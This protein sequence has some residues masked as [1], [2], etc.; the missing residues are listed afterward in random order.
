VILGSHACRTGMLLLEH[1]GIDYR[2]VELPTG[3]HPQLVRLLGFPGR[4]ATPRKVEGGTNPMLA[5][6]DRFGTVPAV[7][8]DGDRV[9]TNLALIDWLDAHY[10]EPPL[11]PAGDEE[12]AQVREA[13]LWGNEVLQMTARRLVFA[14]GL[15]EL[16]ALRGRASHGRMGPLLAHNDLWRTAISQVAA[17]IVFSATPAREQ[18]LRDELADQLGVVDVWLAAGILN[19]PRLNA[20]D[21]MIATSLAL[22]SYVPALEA[23][24]E[25]RPCGALMQRVLPGPVGPRNTPESDP[26]AA[27]GTGVPA[28]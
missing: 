12:R 11:F 1:K 27:S 16:D 2:V 6:M 22:L 26:A 23:D 24:I 25:A 10:P 20:A 9:Q 18:A 13:L 8:I 5:S 4:S 3:L 15:R 17:R 21:L 19:G 28:A 7:R 14:A